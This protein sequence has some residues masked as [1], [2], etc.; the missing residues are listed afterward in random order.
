[1]DQAERARLRSR[2][3]ALANG[4]H[5]HRPEVFGRDLARLRHAVLSGAVCPVAD[6]PLLWTV[7]K[8]LEGTPATDQLS[9][10]CWMLRAR[11]TEAAA[12][13]PTRSDA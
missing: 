5:H 2:I 9:E 7:L 8:R 13:V 3:E 6:H 4:V 1:M 10:V 12:R 11:L